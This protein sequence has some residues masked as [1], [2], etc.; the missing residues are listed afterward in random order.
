MGK[1]VDE[2]TDQLVKA[3]HIQK[4]LIAERMRAEVALRESEEWFRQVAENTREVIWVT[5]PEKNE[6]IYVSSAYEE[7]W[8][9]TCESLYERPRSFLDAID[10]MDRER[11]TTALAKQPLGEYDEEYRIVRRDGTVRWIRDRAFPIRDRRGHVY[12]IVG[13][14]DDIT[15]RKATEEQLRQVQKMEAVGQLTRGVAHDFNNLL[16][17]ITGS[18][19]LLAERLTENERLHRLAQAALGAAL[20]GADLSGRLLTF[21]RR[22]PLAPK[23]IDLNKLISGMTEV[24]QRT[25]SED[26]EIETVT[27]RRL[28]KA[29]ADS[30]QLQNALINLAVNARDAMPAGGMLTIESANVHIDENY[31]AAH[32]DLTA[33]PYVMLAVSDTGTGMSPEVAERAF[34]PFFTTKETDEGSGL[35]LSMVHSFVKQA[36]GQVNI[37]SE[38]SHGTTVKIYLPRASERQVDADPEPPAGAE[39]RGAGETILVV[40]D[41]ADVRRLAHSLLADLGYQVVEAGDGASAL[42]VLDEMPEV[43]LLFTDVVLPGGMCGTELARE[44]RRRR[45]GL[46]VLFTSGYSKKAIVRHGRVDEG[47]ELIEKPYR[48]ASLA[49]KLDS[50]LGRA[51]N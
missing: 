16:T 51:E 36:G 40:E 37:Y 33:G 22:Q 13:I 42:A 6:M 35:G 21:S 30:S 46:K 49:R 10:P 11:V 28:W 48:K 23:V 4:G 12:R 31:A 9:H 32:A 5:D 17:I 29:S 41:D 18:L 47:V 50:I 14:A 39:P 27:A 43:A 20:R 45:H 25:L 7:I 24:L 2:R 3:N 8:G 15:E 38:L 44:A 34:E 1:R 19:E 26:I